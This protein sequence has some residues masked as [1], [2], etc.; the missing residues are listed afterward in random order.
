VIVV[1][2]FARFLGVE[3]EWDR[4]GPAR[5][6]PRSDIWLAVG[7]FVVAAI[8]VELLRGMGAFTDESHSVWPYVA[9][10]T[11]AAL[12][13]WRRNHPLTVAGASALHMFLTGVLMPPVMGSLPM[14]VLYFFALYSGVAW[15]RD[16]RVLTYVVTGVVSLMF[17]WLAWQFAVGSGVAEIRANLGVSADEEGF[18]PPVAA[19]L[20]YTFLINALYFGGAVLLGQVAWRGALRTAQVLAQAATIREQA[21]RLR[22]QAVVAERL[23]IARE[24]HDVVAHHVSV[25]GVQATAA[26]RVLDR[27]PE[28]ARAALG[29]VTSGRADARPAGHVAQR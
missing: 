13:V 10:A 26:A 20:G 14:Q 16:R 17:C 27:D 29:T 3:E 1:E 11:A 5:S 4:P 25:M 28:A 23:R 15:A 6:A 21:E 22:D 12:L 18:I 19:A 8:G 9:V 7:W 2:T 24:L